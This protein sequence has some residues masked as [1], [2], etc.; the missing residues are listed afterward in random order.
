M[1]TVTTQDANWTHLN[2]LELVNNLQVDGNAVIAGSLTY[3]SVTG[4]PSVA[5]GA[6]TT[7]TAANA[8]STFLLNTAAGSVATLPA[9][10]GT[11]NVYNF[12]VTTTVTSNSHKIL[13]ASSSDDI[14]GIAIG[15]HTNTP[16]AFQ[17]TVAGTF[18]S[19]QMPSAGTTPSGGNQGDSFTFQDIGTNLWYVTGTYTAGTTPTTPF[20][21]ATS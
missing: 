15:Q 3:T 8:G 4:L 9:A 2:N 5:V 6:T 11:G 17:A 10:T 18:H 14:I 20:S 16:L 19:I 7:I 1:V 12:I 13:A 21:T